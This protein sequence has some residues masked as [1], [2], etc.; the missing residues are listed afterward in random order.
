MK[1]LRIILL[2]IIGPI[3]QRFRQLSL[4]L[5]GFKNISKKAVIERGVKLDRVYPQHIYIGENTLIASEVTI[6]CHEHVYR[7]PVNPELPLLKKTTIGKRCFIGV[8]A[9][10]LPGVNIGDDCI[11]GAA[12][13][14]AHDIPAG[15][16]A[17]GVPARVVRSNIRLN[18]KAIEIQ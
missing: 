13:V 8:S 14:V 6:L 4:P 5:R 16:V 17:V 9:M 10:V 1:S 11:I 15:S 3:L 7:D 18:D 12:S 2:E